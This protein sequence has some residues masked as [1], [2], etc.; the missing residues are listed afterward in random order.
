MWFSTS[1][2]G[3]SDSNLKLGPKREPTK[4][5][6]YSKNEAITMTEYTVTWSIQVTANSALEAA[7]M[8]EDIQYNQIVNP[9][10]G[11]HFVVR[12]LDTNKMEDIDIKK[13]EEDDQDRRNY[14]SKED[15]HFEG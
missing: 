6:L 5:T 7:L 10:N 11:G 12:N 9:V 1:V 8:A 14:Q 2:F 15:E 4:P 3:S 13:S